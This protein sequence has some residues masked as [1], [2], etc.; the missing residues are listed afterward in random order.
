MTSTL[1]LPA[2]TGIGASDMTDLACTAIM[3]G[4]TGPWSLA[5]ML[6]LTRAQLYLDRCAG[7]QLSGVLQRLMRLRH[8]VRLRRMGE[9]TRAADQQQAKRQKLRAYFQN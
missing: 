5:L 2:S 3:R 6:T 9:H 8:L 1:L 4:R 7:R